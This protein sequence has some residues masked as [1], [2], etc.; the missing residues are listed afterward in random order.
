MMSS[1]EAVNEVFFHQQPPSRS[2]ADHKTATFFKPLQIVK[3]PDEMIE[4][5]IPVLNYENFF[6]S[7]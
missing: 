7:L 1:T 2:E 3:F 5:L 4:L 6:T